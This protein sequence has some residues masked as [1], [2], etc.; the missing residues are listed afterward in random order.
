MSPL[1][2]LGAGEELYRYHEFKQE[3]AVRLSGAG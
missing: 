2:C 1:G 3:P